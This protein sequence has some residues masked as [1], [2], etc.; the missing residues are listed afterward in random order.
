MEKGLNYMLK[1]KAFIKEDNLYDNED[2][3]EPIVKTIY[4]VYE[5]YGII[6]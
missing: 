2:L 6:K 3:A 5:K 1:S 4:T